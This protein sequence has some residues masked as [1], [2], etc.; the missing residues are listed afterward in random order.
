M[1]VLSVDDIR[2]FPPISWLAYNFIPDG[3][4]SVIFGPSNIGKSFFALDLAHSVVTGERWLGR[5][6]RQGP[7]VYV[8]AGEGVSGL[9][10]RIDAWELD[11]GI[12][13]PCDT[14]G[15]LTDAVQLH[16][17]AHV[18]KLIRALKPYEPSL[19]VFDTLAR[20]FVGGNENSVEDM[21]K[22]ISACDEIRSRGTAVLLVHHTGVPDEDEDGKPRHRHRPRGSSG[23]MAAV[24]SAIEICLP[25][26]EVDL[27]STSDRVV[28][29]RKQKDAEWFHPITARLR[30]VRK[31]GKTLSLVPAV[32]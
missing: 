9:R 32:G 17:S 6:V 4:L 21:G 11:R 29:C 1:R 30:H 16:Q 10:Q 24:D 5:R 14:M 8:A 2:A 28:R 7:V 19:V 12:E 26:G 18:D 20:C 31:A 15:Y 13:I 23:L 27:D 25:T 22:V 3:S